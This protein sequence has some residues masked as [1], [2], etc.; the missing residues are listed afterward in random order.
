MV[1][2][3]QSNLFWEIMRFV[4][5]GVLATIVDYAGK[6]G[7]AY[8]LSKV[9]D[10]SLPVYKYLSLG[11][12]VLAG[13]AISVVVNY[14]LS[15]LWVFQNVENKKSSNKKFW[16]FVLLGLIGWLISEIIFYASLFILKNWS[17]DIQAG[18]ELFFATVKPESFWH[19]VG[20]VFS[21]PD[22]VAY[23][24]VFV[25]STLIVLVWNYL[26]RKKW[27]FKPVSHDHR[28]EEDLEK[29]IN[30]VKEVK[31]K[32]GLREVVVKPAEA[33][34]FESEEVEE[35]PTPVKTPIV[36]E[37]NKKPSGKYE[38]F[39]EAGFYKYCLKANNGEILVV[40]H[41]YKNR[42]SAHEGIETFKRNVPEGVCS[43][44]TD[45]N[46]YSQ[47]KIF[48]PNDGQLI[49]S[50]EIYSTADSAN[51]ALASVKDFYWTTRVIDLE[52]I[53]TSQI[54][55]WVIPFGEFQDKPNGKII[56][57]I[58]PETGKW[59]ARLLAN[60]GQILFETD[61]SYVG[62]SGAI[63]GISAI[64]NRFKEGNFHVVKDKQGRFQFCICN[65]TGVILLRGESYPTKDSAISAAISAASFLAKAEE[66]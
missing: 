11:L 54:R 58:I 16:L 64:K 53:E 30:V 15:L 14:L 29:E 66:A 3:K 62:K 46:G 42:K 35:K 28:I 22:F 21:T 31:D 7:C 2:K 47:W 20:V 8:L 45:K 18:S 57:F 5:V 12:S 43:V 19:D 38:V 23:S 56:Y 48:T 49:A 44:T 65:S 40:S 4:L 34:V 10:T 9:W 24:I 51:N 17:I 41:G 32:N 52:E 33:D 6:T 26:S 13:F 55:D 36:E 63:D 1:S 60:N 37:D 50:G 25:V 27:I 59:K 61:S 39:P